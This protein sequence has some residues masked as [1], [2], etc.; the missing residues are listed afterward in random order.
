MPK[1]F[2]SL[3]QTNSITSFQPFKQSSWV[4]KMSLFKLIILKFA[5]RHF[6]KH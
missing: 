2:T 6:S 1:I 4:Q 3:L 5:K